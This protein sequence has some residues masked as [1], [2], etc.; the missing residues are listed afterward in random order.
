MPLRDYF[1]SPQV[2]V[3]RRTFWN[4]WTAPAFTGPIS[5]KDRPLQRNNFVSKCAALLKQEVRVVLE[6]IVTIRTNNLYPE[7]LD[8]FELTDFDMSNND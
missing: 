4:A 2:Q 5:Y 7:L 3:R 8:H 6:D 1:R